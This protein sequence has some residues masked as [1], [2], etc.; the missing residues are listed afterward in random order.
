MGEAE[1]GLTKRK[2]LEINYYPKGILE[3]LQ[4][5][6]QPF[7]IRV[8]V[9]SR[10]ILRKFHSRLVQIL[11]H[12]SLEIDLVETSPSDIPN[13]EVLMTVHPKDNI[14]VE[15]AVKNLERYSKNKITKFTVITTEENVD[16]LTKLL[17][18]DDRFEIFSEQ[19]SPV[20]EILEI[21]KEIG[22]ERYGHIL[23][24]LLKI[25]HCAVSVGEFTLVFDSDTFLNHST[26]WV[27]SELQSGIFPTFHAANADKRLVELFPGF[28]K[29]NTNECYIS[30]HLVFNREI[31]L[32][33]LLDL[34]KFQIESKFELEPILGK[35]EESLV[36]KFQGLINYAKLGHDM[37][38]YDS[39]SKYAFTNFSNEVVELRWSNMTLFLEDF[40]SL[41]AAQLFETNKD[42]SDFKNMFRTVSIHDHL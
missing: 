39:Y 26:L 37:S 9:I 30:H 1:M 14:Q 6:H 35:L 12:G 34:S 24:Q 19:K 11:R 15:D 32:A 31:L 13:I 16:Y 28:V 3:R 4:R 27:N 38:E 17:G 8:L 21:L 22:G 10:P 5:I 2:R 33:F 42:A 23:Q 40:Q 7:W 36:D 25:W 20:W 18:R 29:W 41:S